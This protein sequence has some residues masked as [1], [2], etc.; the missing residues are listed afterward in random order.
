MKT[1]PL[2]SISVFGVVAMLLISG[3]ASP[4]I[5]DQAQLSR[6]AMLFSDSPALAGSAELISTIEPGT[7]SRGGASASGCTVCR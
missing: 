7:D 5:S 1:K 2:K 3:C 6:S 4:S